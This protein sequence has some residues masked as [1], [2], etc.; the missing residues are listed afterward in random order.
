MTADYLRQEPS[1]MS[2]V[3]KQFSSGVDTFPW[4]AFHLIYY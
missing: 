4:I 2:N 3:P 1:G